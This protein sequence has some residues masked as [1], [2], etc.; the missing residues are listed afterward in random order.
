MILSGIPFSI[1]VWRTGIGDA[2]LYTT[3]VSPSLA[4]GAMG[5]LIGDPFNEFLRL[6]WKF[7]HFLWRS[8]L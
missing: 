4:L 1:G 8:Y 7:F 5:T 2:S 3:I 6:Q